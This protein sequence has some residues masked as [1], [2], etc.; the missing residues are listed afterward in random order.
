METVLPT[1]TCP[2]LLLQAD[3]AAGALMTDA[4]VAQALRLLAHPTHVQ[5]AGVGHPLHATHATVVLDAL[6]SFL[7]PLRTP[8]KLSEQTGM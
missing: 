7:E 8:E 3:P 1:I 4:E 2:V 5:L 6:R